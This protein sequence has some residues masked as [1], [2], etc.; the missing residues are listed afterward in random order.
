MAEAFG[1]YLILT[2]PVAG[3]EACAA[4]AVRCGVRYLQLRMKG[5]PRDVFLAMAR[6]LRRTTF[7]SD[8]L[9][10]VNDDVEVAR[11]AGADG[12]HLGQDDLPL[13]E[14]RLAWPAPGRR[15]GLSTHDERQARRAAR[16]APDYIGVGPVFATPTK[17]T[18]DPVLGLERM[19]AIIRSSAV[20]AVAIGGIDHV[21]L[22]HV[23]RAGATNFAVVRAVNRRP[24]P[25]AAIREL[26]RIW[27]QVFRQ[28]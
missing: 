6:A 26:Q 15:F 19:G 24:D 12:V 28:D 7:G 1:L 17:A 9:L 20:T 22:V 18:P 16:E 14:A 13:A 25:E 3:Y 21:N 10:I 23:L 4:A 27:R 8:T 5:V 11:D 2:D